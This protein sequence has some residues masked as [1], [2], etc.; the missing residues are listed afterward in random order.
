MPVDE[1]LS[2]VIVVRP[3]WH[4]IVVVLLTVFLCFGGL[5]V[6]ILRQDAQSP[7]ELIIKVLLALVLSTGGI[8]VIGNIVGDTFTRFTDAQ[9]QRPSLFG[10]KRYRWDDLKLIRGR[11]NL[12]DFV[13]STGT[14]RMN[15]Y[16]FANSQEMIRFVRKRVP[17]AL[18][19]ASS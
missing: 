2:P 19:D 4:V 15:F 17:E 13:F 8:F 5:A 9:L 6:V 3:K 7:A 10:M 12:V 16:L 1:R 14:F 18:I 11:G